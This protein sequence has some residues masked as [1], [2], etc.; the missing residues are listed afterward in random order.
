M[1]ER[2]EVREVVWK[3]RRKRGVGVGLWTGM[4][5]PLPYQ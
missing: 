2:S 5:R 1:N 4:R 3:V